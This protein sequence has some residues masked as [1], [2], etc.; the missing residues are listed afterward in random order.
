MESYLKTTKNNRKRVDCRH[1]EMICYVD[2]YL[3]VYEVNK[4]IIFKKQTNSFFFRKIFNKL[5]IKSFSKNV[6]FI[7]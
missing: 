5:K 3:F 2:L 4:Y 1:I 6:L 7:L